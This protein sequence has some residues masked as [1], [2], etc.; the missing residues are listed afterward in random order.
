[1]PPATYSGLVDHIIGIINILIPGVF[2]LV[3]VYFVWKMI[4]AWIIRVGDEKGRE[5]GKQYAMAA[6]IALVLM[7]STWAIVAIIKSSLF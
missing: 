6:V 7:L 5:E 1:M 4:D 3:F 2:A